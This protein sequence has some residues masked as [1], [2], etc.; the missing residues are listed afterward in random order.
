M[1]CMVGKKSYKIIIEF[2]NAQGQTFPIMNCVF[3][4]S[5]GV[6]CFPPSQSIGDKHN[7]SVSQ[8]NCAI[9]VI[10]VVNTADT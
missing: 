3:K 9:N 1:G 7:I 6:K 10:V 8:I 4:E 2:R 5:L